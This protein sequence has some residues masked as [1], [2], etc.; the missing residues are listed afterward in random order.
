MATIAEQL[1]S[2]ADTKTAIKNAIV[3]KGVSVADTDPFS[4]YASKIGQISGGG[5]GEV[6][7]KEKFGATIDTFLGNVNAN[8]TLETSTW[9]GALNF[10]GVKNIN[11]YVLQYAFYNCTGI[12]SVD[13]SSLQNIYDYGL[14]RAFYGCTG[15]TSVDLSS[16]QSVST[17]GLQYAFYNCRGITSV[18]LSSLL[19]IYPNG[20]QYAFYGCRGIT[21]VDLSSL[22]S[23][24]SSGIKSAFYGC[25][26]ITTISFPS[27]TSVQKD[28]FGSSST[29]GAF[30]DCTGMTEIHFRAD[31]QSTIEAMS[32]YSNKWGATN[33]TIYF[34]L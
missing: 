13:L 1:T 8:G 12:T 14:S 6:V 9:A 27:L 34:D 23:V 22:K 30:R 31:M 17:Y 4:A 3:A 24:L 7:N 26:G 2:L 33:A 28:S 5:G 11:S 29:D 10:S 18:D 16:L 32:Q 21:S 20:L 15:I 19:T 25:T